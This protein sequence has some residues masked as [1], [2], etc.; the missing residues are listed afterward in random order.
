L[1]TF[2]KAPRIASIAAPLLIVA[3]SLDEAAPIERLF[4]PDTESTLVGVF[5]R[6]NPQLEPVVDLRDASSTRAPAVSLD[7]TSGDRQHTK[8]I[9]VLI[10]DAIN[11]VEP[12]T[13]AIGLGML[14]GDDI[15]ASDAALQA[16]R[17]AR[18]RIRWMC[19]FAGDAD[20]DEGR[21]ARRRMSL[22]VRGVRLEPVA[23][24]EVPMGSSARFW[25]IRAPRRY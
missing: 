15:E 5:A 3:T 10:A 12:S 17:F 19:Y 1:R 7:R 21:V 24:A 20:V 11:S 23:I 2:A 4:G 9:G 18:P 8:D 13:V 14:G 22:F 25:E 6:S 16:R